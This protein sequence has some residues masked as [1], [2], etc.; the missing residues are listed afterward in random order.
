MECA[1]FV[2][3]IYSAIIFH[4]CILISGSNKL[5]NMTYYDWLLKF[6]STISQCMQRFLYLTRETRPTVSDT[7]GNFS[8]LVDF[9]IHTNMCTTASIL[10]PVQTPLKSGRHKGHFLFAD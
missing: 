1:L 8:L 10:L 6:E 5:Y 4:C 3:I 9:R 7:F 2:Y